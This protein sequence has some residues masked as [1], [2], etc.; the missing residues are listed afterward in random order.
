MFNAACRALEARSGHA[1]RLTSRT[2]AVRSRAF[3]PAALA[4]CLALL[5]AG[6]ASV[7][8]AEEAPAKYDPALEPLAYLAG[9]CWEGPLPDF[10]GTSL[11]YGN[12]GLTHCFRWALEGRVL[13]DSLHIAGQKPEIRGETTY[14]YDAAR[15]VLR[16]QFWSIGPSYSYGTVRIEGNKLIF[17]DEELFGRNGLIRYTSTWTRTGSDRYVQNRQRLEKDG[18]WTRSPEGTFNRKPLR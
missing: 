4:A 7:R 15:Q 9:S 8:G 13:R 14:Y 11:G 18:K 6:A 10:V 17:D 12:A 16:Y 5:G 3:L 2:G 1:S